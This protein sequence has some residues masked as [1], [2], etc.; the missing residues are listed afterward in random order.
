MF[1]TSTSA[2][3]A[4]TAEESN[5]F[6]L[7]VSYFGDNTLNPGLRVG[8]SHTLLRQVKVKTYKSQKK[9]SKKGSKTKVIQYKI[10]G[11]LGFYNQPNNH[12]GLIF[13]TGITRHKNKNERKLSTAFSFE[14]NY[15]QRFYNIE[16]FE[17]DE[18]GEITELGLVGNGGLAFALAPSVERSFGEN[19]W[20][21]FF[22]P[23]LQMVKYN[24]AYAL[25]YFVEL[26]LSLNL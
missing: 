22:K 21:V 20:I 25:N 2:Q 5:G 15:L 6:P 24:H 14:I 16:T 13:G 4:E 26:G 8:T 9:K 17:I 23:G 7:R 3:R 18:T 19:E 1:S 10:D 12:S 11:N